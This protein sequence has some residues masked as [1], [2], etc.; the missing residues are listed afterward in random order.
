VK[1]LLAYLRTPWRTPREPKEPPRTALHVCGVDCDADPAATTMP[2]PALPDQAEGHE[3]AM[4]VHQEHVG[5]EED[6]SPLAE[7]AAAAD[8]PT[9][10]VSIPETS[11]E[12]AEHNQELHD[13]LSDIVARF[14]AAS[15]EWWAQWLDRIG[16]SAGE[17]AVVDFDTAEWELVSA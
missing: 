10:A 1:R 13:A 6:W 17:V 7:T 12:H 3:P 2:L 15:D 11:A 16:V 4:V 5:A 14:H 8:L 9:D